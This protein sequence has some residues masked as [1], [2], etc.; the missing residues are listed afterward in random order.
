[1]SMPPLLQQLGVL[2]RPIV[3]DHADQAH[4]REVAGGVGEENRRAA[5]HVVATL[6]RRFNT[7]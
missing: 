3:A 5:E 1:M 7:I 2:G 4:R 6:G